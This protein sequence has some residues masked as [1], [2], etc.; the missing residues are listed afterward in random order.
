MPSPRKLD[1]IPSELRD[2]LAKTLAANGFANILA[3]TED[4]NVWLDETGCE[5]RIGKTAVG[6]FSKLLKDQRDAFALA[7]TLLSDM[8]IEQ[9]SNMHRA[10]MQ[11]IAASAVQMM[12][13]VR[14]DDG[15]LEP[16]DLMALGRMLK[17][18]MQSAGFREKLR[19]DERRRVAAEARDA[20]RAALEARLDAATAAGGAEA[21]AAA[22]ARR[23]LGFG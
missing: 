10:L 14:E 15:H 2:R 17:D 7:E 3:V 9:E 20:E 19:E 1:L 21:A 11:M 22:E 12:K 4:L 18:L 6:E 16:K 5:L 13:A 23:I 8:D